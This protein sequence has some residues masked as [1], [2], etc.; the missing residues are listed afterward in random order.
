MKPK[1]RKKIGL[2]DSDPKSIMHRPEELTAP[3]QAL[4][5]AIIR[6]FTKNKL[7]KFV[8]EQIEF[9][10]FN[11]HLVGSMRILFDE[12]GKLPKNAPIHDIIAAKE[13]IE[14][15]IKFLEAVCSAMRNQLAEIR[16]IEQAAFE[17]LASKGEE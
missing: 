8:R 5:E 17:S 13:R 2:I 7:N 11:R 12:N 4:R 3:Q 9:V 16:D 15:E 14:N 1:E 10:N 6:R